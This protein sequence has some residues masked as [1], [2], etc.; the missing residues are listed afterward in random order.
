MRRVVLCIMFAGLTI[1]SLGQTSKAP[2]SRAK[3]HV[4][5]SAALDRDAKYRILLPR[6]YANGKGRFPVLYLLHGLYGDDLNWDTL[7]GLERYARNLPLIIVMADA[8]NSWYTNSASDPKDKFEDY[9]AK[10]LIDE[11]D[12]KYRTIPVQRA[13][14]VAGLS[15]GG[16]GAI[17][18]AMKYPDEFVLAGSLSGALDAGRDL[19]KRVA[20]FHDQLVKVFGADDSTTRKDNDVFRLVE[21][22]DVSQLPYLYLACGEQDE[23]FLKTNREFVEQLSARKIAYEY[24][25][26]LGAHA[27]DYWD[28]SL[29]SMLPVITKRLSPG[30]VAFRGRGGRDGSL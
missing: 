23:N 8:G 5:H 22:V 27:W 19:D 18:L 14:A 2:L 21:R 9:T 26:T 1:L 6:G 24:H 7:T 4:F 15:M 13:R 20:E 25:E 17:K 12:A 16:Y 30:G 29:R 10:D 28:R 11:I 3:D